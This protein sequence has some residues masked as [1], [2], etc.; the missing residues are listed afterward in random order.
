MGGLRSGA[1]HEWLVEGGRGEPFAGPLGV[2][3][4]LAQQ[5]LERLTG[6]RLVLWIGR[7]CW[8][9]PQALSGS[10]LAC[11]VFV[12]ADDR[13]ERVWA[14][15][16]ALRSPAAGV[17]AVDARGFDMSASR[18]LQL[19]AGVG[20]GVCLL[21]RP[22]AER[23]ALSAAW[24]RWRVT[25]VLSDSASPRWAIDLLRCKGVRP[26]QEG[27]HHWCV[28]HDHETGDVR[29]VPNVCDRRVAPACPAAT[30]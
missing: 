12:D 23:R 20:G 26:A 5:A 9:H 13:S 29:V 27:A 1:I 11:S 17:V 7:S 30:A 22:W 21:T 8:P 2:W 19:A 10:V 15:D 16:L 18:R 4:H 3:T 14:A 28:Q 24:T 6:T 25:P